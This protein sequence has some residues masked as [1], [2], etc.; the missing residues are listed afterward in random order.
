MQKLQGESSKLPRKFYQTDLK[1]LGSNIESK[2][3]KYL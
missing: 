1:E 2:L 3:N